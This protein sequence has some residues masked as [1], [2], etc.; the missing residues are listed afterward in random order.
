MCS[1]WTSSYIR[2]LFEISADQPTFTNLFSFHRKLRETNSFEE[3]IAIKERKDK[4]D[5][6]TY[7]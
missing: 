7:N 1:N 5:M 6:E 2:T 4:T 3:T